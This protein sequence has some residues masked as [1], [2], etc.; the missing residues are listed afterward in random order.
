MWFT[1]HTF[2]HKEVWKKNF[3]FLFLLQKYLEKKFKYLKIKIKIKA[4]NRKNKNVKFKNEVERKEFL[5]LCNVPPSI[6]QS[7]QDFGTFSK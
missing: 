3:H 2:L 5:N 4:T 1:Y 6:H 7:R